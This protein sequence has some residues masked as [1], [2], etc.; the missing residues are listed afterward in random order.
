[1]ALCAVCH[2]Q[3]NPYKIK[4]ELYR[5]YTD[6]YRNRTTVKGL[7]MSTKL[8]NRAVTL[9]DRR[10]QCIALTL[11]V[12]Y[13]Y[14]NSGNHPEQFFNAVKKLQDTALRYGEEHYY[15]FGFSNEVNFLINNRRIDDA[16]RLATETAEFAKKND[17]KFGIYTCLYVNGQLCI[18]CNEIHI[19]LQYYNEALKAATSLM[20]DADRSNLYRKI[21]DCYANLYMYDRMYDYALKAYTQSRTDISRMRTLR[22]VCYAALML[23]RDEEFAHY[24]NIYNSLKGGNISTDS[25]DIEERDIA[26]L[27]LLHD[28]DF[29]KAYS[30]I[31]KQN[32]ELP[33]LRLLE[34]YYRM[35]GDLR[36][37]AATQAK[38]YR[39]HI[40]ECDNVRSHNFEATFAMFFNMRLNLQNQILGTARQRLETDHQATELKN[41]QLRLANTQ[42]TLRNSALELSKTRS[43]AD[44]LKMSYDKKLLE[45]AKLHGELK[46]AKIRQSFGNMMSVLGATIGVL[47]TVAIGIYLWTRSKIMYDLQ[48]ANNVLEQN[49]AQLT[50]AKAHAENANN[51]KTAFIQNM[52]GEIRT[53]LDDVIGIAGAIADAN[54]P[55]ERLA[56]LNRMLTKSTRELLGLVDNTL[57]KT[58]QPPSTITPPHLTTTI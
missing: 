6:A 17:H 58:Q 16:V 1:M 53:P 54:T 15:Y 46:A 44:V 45:A 48:H 55:P 9:G 27:K 23:D 5:M 39:L 3:N 42:L 8:Y 12:S 29:D 11:P 10:A 7:Q 41:A 33:R 50:R 21:A 25:R 24:F 30:A 49:N 31:A 28:R 22:D 43:E 4:D 51:V 14:Y 36:Q 19:A 34:K 26:T 57:D 13:F 32:R 2:A 56:E 40:Q 38:M 37:L 18:A 20:P 47:L 35:R 52:A